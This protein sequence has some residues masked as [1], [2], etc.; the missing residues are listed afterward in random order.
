MKSRKPRPAKPHLKRSLLSSQ[1]HNRRLEEDLMWSSQ[2]RE[3]ERRES[4]RTRERRS[5]PPAGPRMR[6]DQT[7]LESRPRRE[8]RRRPQLDSAMRNAR[9]QGQNSL[10]WTKKLLDFEEREPD[11]WG[12]SGFRELY[13]DQPSAGGGR[14]ARSRERQ[15]RERQE[16]QERPERGRRQSGAPGSARRP[17]EL[18]AAAA[19]A[20]AASES[21]ESSSSSGAEEAV[22]TSLSER[23][24][25]LAQLSV[26]RGAAELVRLRIVKDANSSD[27][28]V[29]LEEEPGG[30]RE[31]SQERVSFESEYREYFGQ[32]L[33]RA[34]VTDDPGDQLP[35]QLPRDWETDVSVR[36]RYYRD[37]GYFRDHMLT[38]EEYIK[39][40]QWWYRYREWLAKEARRPRVE[41]PPLETVA[42]VRRLRPVDWPDRRR[43][44]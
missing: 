44:F 5:P 31:R 41:R 23:F 27:K 15:S 1:F 25:R 32:K 12:H 33:R 28:K 30:A 22:R 37:A 7:R 14:S 10:Y 35:R 9:R 40:E 3:R 6:M 18:V 42:P 29:I 16:R 26:Q 34:A 13:L 39:W 43:R 21:A 8:E 4:R 11:R 2:A 19:P 17:P 24:G 36:Y 20:A 38:L